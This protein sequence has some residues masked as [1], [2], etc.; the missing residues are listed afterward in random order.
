MDETA[1]DEEGIVRWLIKQIQ[2]T[3]ILDRLN[4]LGECIAFDTESGDAYTKNERS[5]ELLRQHW[6]EQKQKIESG[7]C[8][9]HGTQPEDEALV[10]EQNP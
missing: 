6:F 2:E 3:T 5:V 10:I 9:A 1:T 7:A 4:F 8:V